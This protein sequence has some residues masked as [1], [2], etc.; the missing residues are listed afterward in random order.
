MAHIRPGSNTAGADDDDALQL[1]QL[2]DTEIRV[3][4]TNQRPEWQDAWDVTE[5]LLVAARDASEAANARFLLVNAP[6]VWEIYQS[7]WESFR[8]ANG[9]RAD[10]WDLEAARRR[11]A[12]L[13]TRHG[14]EYLDLTPSLTAA[15]AAEPSLYFSRDLHWTAAGHRVVGQALA[16]RVEAKFAVALGR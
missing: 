3:F 2:I 14:I 5:A 6:T 16:E 15:V 12:A 9:L 8:D 1:D 4:A 7:R 11:L 10:G 13:A